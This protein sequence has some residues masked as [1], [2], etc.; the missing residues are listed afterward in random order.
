MFS[1]QELSSRNM[2]RGK[3]KRVSLR[4]IRPVD[5]RKANEKYKKVRGICT[6]LYSNRVIDQ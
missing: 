4:G 1:E 5:G 2:M 6:L 3:W